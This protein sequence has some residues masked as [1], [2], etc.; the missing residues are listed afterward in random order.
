MS[1]DRPEPDQLV[2]VVS[3]ERIFRLIHPSWYKDGHLQ[4]A[5][6]QTKEWKGKPSKTDYGPS[7]FVV[8]KLAPEQ[9]AGA[10]RHPDI[11]ALVSANP[12]WSTWG[13]AEIPVG[14][15]EERGLVVRLSPMD[16]QQFPALKQAHASLFGVTS[17]TRD[18]VV[19]ALDRYIISRGPEGILRPPKG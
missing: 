7:V 16:C 6:L 1:G 8:S 9:D 15:L 3:A 5:C 18:M 10:C 14:V 12:S 4:S 19:E 13:L 11:A 17:D 2:R